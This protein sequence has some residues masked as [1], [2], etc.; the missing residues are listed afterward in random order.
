MQFPEHTV[1]S[2]TAGALMGAGI[3]ECDVTFTKDLE[4]VCRHSQVCRLVVCSWR[5]FSSLRC[6]IF[7]IFI[8]SLIASHSAIS[9]PPPT[10]FFVKT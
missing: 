9:T 7:N 1:E 3:L 2:Y 5:C 8:A 10:S 4:L 6:C